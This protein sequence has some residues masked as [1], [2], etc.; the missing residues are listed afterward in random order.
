ME[1]MSASD[2]QSA[3]PVPKQRRCRHSFWMILLIVG[4]CLVSC[5][6]FAVRWFQ[7]ITAARE[8]V[9][10]LNGKAVVYFEG[11]NYVGED[12]AP[13]SRPPGPIGTDAIVEGIC[14]G[15]QLTDADMVYLRKMPQ[16][17]ILDLSDTSIT[18]KGLEHIRDAS[19][20]E[21]LWPP[22]S[23]SDADLEPI[24]GQRQLKGLD[25]SYRRQITDRGL[26]YLSGLDGLRILGIQGTKVTD[27]GL[28]HL[29]R[30]KSLETLYLYETSVTDAGLAHLKTLPKLRD[31]LL[32]QTQ[33]TD[34]GLVHLRGLTDLRELYLGSTPI[35]GEG[36]V[37]LQ[38]LVHLEQLRF[39]STN[40]GDASLVYIGKLTNLKDLWLNETQ[41]TDA[42]LEHLLGLTELK[43]I[44]FDNTRVTEA[45]VTKLRKA[46][47]ECEM[48]TGQYGEFFNKAR[49]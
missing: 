5:V 18:G 27:A 3:P 15:R 7:A 1:S 13:I 19:H 30:L 21:A 49:K 28:R 36:L 47:P 25:L 10:A 14:G 44:N 39:D 31:L 2:Y 22:R 41:V 20:L 37:H 11:D 48:Q 38:S 45:G 26:M 8:G 29:G 6:C 32:Y 46:L 34:A 9:N 12:A 23:I 4:G 24:S 43:F 16:L 42:G 17:R 35:R 33:V 40:I